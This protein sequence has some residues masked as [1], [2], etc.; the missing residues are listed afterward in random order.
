MSWWDEYGPGSYDDSSDYGSE[1]GCYRESDLSC[2]EY[3]S[4]D[5]QDYIKRRAWARDGKA[6]RAACDSPW[7]GADSVGEMFDDADEDLDA[8]NDSFIPGIDDID[9][10]MWKPPADEHE[11]TADEVE[12]LLADAALPLEQVAACLEER[13]YL[14]GVFLRP[15]RAAEA[16]GYDDI[17]SMGSFVLENDTRRFVD[18][19][20]LPMRMLR[21][22]TEY[23]TLRAFDTGA[24]RG[25]GAC[26]AEEIRKGDIVIEAVGQLLGD[27][28][29]ERLTSATYVVSYDDPQLEALR[30]AG[31][32]H[33]L[34]IDARECG[35]MM[36]LVNDDT[37]APNLEL[38]YWPPA[39]ALPQR[40]F[41]VATADIPAYTELCWDYGEHYHRNW[42]EVAKRHP[43]KQLATWAARK[44]APMPSVRKVKARKSAAGDG[45]ATWGAGRAKKVKA[46]KSA[47]HAV[48]E[49][50]GYSGEE[51]DDDDDEEEEEEEEEE[52]D[53][54]EEDEDDDE[55]DESADDEELDEGEETEYE[56]LDY[57]GRPL[58]WEQQVGGADERL[59]QLRAQVAEDSGIGAHG[60][61]EGQFGLWEAIEKVRAP[62]KPGDQEGGVRRLQLLLQRLCRRDELIRENGPNSGGSRGELR[63]QQAPDSDS[64]SGDYDSFPV[65]LEDWATL[66]IGGR[67]NFVRMISTLDQTAVDDEDTLHEQLAK[68]CDG[69]QL[70]RWP[71]PLFDASAW[72]RT[73]SFINSDRSVFDK[74]HPQLRGRM[75]FSQ[76][77]GCVCS[78][79]AEEREARRAKQVAE[80]R[81]LHDAAASA[82]MHGADPLE[83]AIADAALCVLRDAHDRMHIHLTTL[84]NGDALVNDDSIAHE[85][86]NLLDILHGRSGSRRQLAAHLHSSGA[87]GVLS[88]TWSASCAHL[89]SLAREIF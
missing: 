66:P 32:G 6:L 77:A 89:S 59:G 76:P 84:A 47:P 2:S 16:L 87:I 69:C 62:S 64:D 10:E 8:R 55:S 23:D 18:S 88:A 35:N 9:A 24:L 74:R 80:V 85:A 67:T 71:Q 75:L 73:A 36:R 33:R 19:G 4:D 51:D 60:A 58:V 54:E 81:G 38:V 20:P 46:R 56:D 29:F 68:R 70:E 72:P 28:E 57:N 1:Y 5:D 50:Q 83:A 14:D 26:C 15:D 7:S 45:S 11:E 12:A 31:E 40:A 3:V 25:W 78:C 86:L 61:L 27:A 43:R 44:S 53:D 42:L 48:E 52:D 82:A 37:D 41:L 65:T 34:Y 21:R 49:E 39:P 79:T 13:A 30:A 17:N 22:Y 63:Q